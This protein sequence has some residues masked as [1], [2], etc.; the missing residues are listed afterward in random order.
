MS[1]SAPPDGNSVVHAAARPVTAR[2]AKATSSVR[3]QR[4]PHTLWALACIVLGVVG[5]AHNLRLLPPGTLSDVAAFWPALLIGLGAF[6]VLTRRIPLGFGSSSPFAIERGASQTGQLQIAT[7][8]ADVLVGAF[9]GASQLAVGRFPAHGGPRLLTDGSRARL[10][11]DHRAVP[12]FAPGDWSVSLVKGLPWA[13]RLQSDVGHVHLNLRDLNVTTLDLRS[14]FGNVDLVLPAT[15]QGEVE[16]RLSFGDLVVRVP[17]RMAVKI[18]LT[19][20]PFTEVTITDPR[21][22]RTA[23]N[24]WVTPYFSASPHRFSL[25]IALTMGDLLVA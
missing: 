7:R 13:L 24:E 8:W 23:Q 6:I 11:L 16:A 20:G 2:A 10:V 15:G 18:R 14:H 21:L 1:A 4:S 22:I 25:T 3:G 9:A 5:L 19:A 17:E 12:L